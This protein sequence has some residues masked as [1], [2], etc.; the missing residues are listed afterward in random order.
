MYFFFLFWDVHEAGD[1]AGT[2]EP[3]A[4]SSDLSEICSPPLGDFEQEMQIYLQED[5]EPNENSGNSIDK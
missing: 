4:L 1:G 3:G 5:W 2:E